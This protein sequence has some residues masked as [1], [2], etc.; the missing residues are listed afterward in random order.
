MTT[1]AFSAHR[2][3]SFLP[4]ASLPDLVGSASFAAPCLDDHGRDLVFSALRVDLAQPVLNQPRRRAA[5][6]GTAPSCSARGT[7]VWAPRVAAMG[8]F[9]KRKKS[10]RHSEPR[11]ETA[12][13]QASPRPAAAPFWL[14]LDHWRWLHVPAFY[15]GCRHPLNKE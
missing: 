15:R 8:L 13:W 3:V 11:G 9:R 2:L 5:C 4:L 10:L 12:H 7:L 1:T 14:G 6:P